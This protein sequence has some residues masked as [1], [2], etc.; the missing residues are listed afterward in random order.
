MTII[1]SVYFVFF[2]VELLHKGTQRRHKV[3]QRVLNYVI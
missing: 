3:A 2:L 1:F